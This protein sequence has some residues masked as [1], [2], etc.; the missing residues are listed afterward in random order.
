MDRIV[1]RDVSVSGN[2]GANGWPT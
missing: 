1:S 2:C